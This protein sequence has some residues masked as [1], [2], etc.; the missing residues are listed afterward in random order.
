MSTWG[1]CTG[2]GATSIHGQSPDQN[3]MH[4]RQSWC[5]NAFVVQC[6]TKGFPHW[7][8]QKAQREMDMKEIYIHE[9]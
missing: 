8:K 2:L 7:Q 5:E 1:K 9:I 3:A 6:T 4:Q